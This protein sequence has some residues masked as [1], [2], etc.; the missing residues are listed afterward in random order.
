MIDSIELCSCLFPTSFPSIYIYFASEE[1][2][3]ALQTCFIHL[4]FSDHE[5]PGHL[6]YEEA[7]ARRV[8]SH[9]LAM[10][11]AALQQLHQR[12]LN[13]SSNTITN[14]PQS[15]RL[16][17]RSNSSSSSSKAAVVNQP[18][19]NFNSYLPPSPP[20]SRSPSPYGL[21][22]SGGAGEGPR[23][24]MSTAATSTTTSAYLQPQ[25][26]PGGAAS[27][28]SGSQ[29]G[30]AACAPASAAISTA[31]MQRRPS[32][33]GDVPGYRADSSQV[34][35]SPSSDQLHHVN[36]HHP[37]ANG[38]ANGHA[39]G[40]LDHHHQ[41]PPLARSPVSASFPASIASAPFISSVY[42]KANGL[43]KELPF[44][45][46]SPAS[47]PTHSNI[48]T[49]RHHLQPL[50]ASQ[51]H[52]RR[53]SVAQAITPS[54]STVRFASLCA[55]WYTSSALSSNTG[56]S[57]LN[58]FK[59]PV[60]LTFIQFGFVAGWCVIVC[61]GR[62][63]FAQLSANKQNSH[64]H[65]HHSRSL[66]IGQLHAASGWGIKKPSK[67]ALE[68]TLVMSGFQIAGHIFSSMAI[69]RVPV[70]TVHTIKVSRCR[71]RAPKGPANSIRTCF[72]NFAGIVAFVYRSL[73]WPALPSQILV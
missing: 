41:H 45:P 3:T 26:S 31:T 60:T 1:T 61:V 14:E 2:S 27:P 40:S 33:N 37:Y 28:V 58:R 24:R 70:S 23:L 64:G 20:R 18:V 56:K 69:A 22:S 4:C 25:Y 19:P 39:N 54:I 62:T 55:L 9:S 42:S 15:L 10:S 68:G 72:F 30:N 71:I 65:Q 63:K 12:G 16:E 66:S 73:V 52:N 46:L 35:A 57:I 17:Q 32:Q 6:R 51:G 59:Y 8:E 67:K 13:T 38:Y 5:R 7:N 21:S 48:S 29:H 43:I 36:F 44:S 11:G 34:D 47:L 50:S 49:Q 53:H